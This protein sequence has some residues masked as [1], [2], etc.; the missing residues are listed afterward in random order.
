MKVDLD[1]KFV[2]VT[3]GNTLTVKLPVQDVVWEAS[4]LAL[5]LLEKGKG[6]FLCQGNN[7]SVA[8]SCEDGQATKVS[9]CF[10]R[11]GKEVKVEKALEEGNFPV[12]GVILLVTSHIEGVILGGL[13]LPV[14]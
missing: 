2:S 8:V 13:D 5:D 4:G 14:N 6:T 7:G 9:T 12:L 3:E 11:E 1:R 10:T